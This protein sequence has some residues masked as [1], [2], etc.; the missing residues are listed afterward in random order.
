M[1][2]SA[3]AGDACSVVVVAIA[4]VLVVLVVDCWLL[5]VCLLLLFVRFV[6]ARRRYP[7]FK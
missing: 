6:R 2:V 7:L 3:V 4:V 1:A 5:V